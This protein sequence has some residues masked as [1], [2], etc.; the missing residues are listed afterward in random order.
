ML[1][2]DQAGITVTHTRH[3]SADM[4]RYVREADKGNNS[5]L[6]GVLYAAAPAA[7]RAL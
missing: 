3:K 7:R 4:A 1:A 2:C 5:R 6:R